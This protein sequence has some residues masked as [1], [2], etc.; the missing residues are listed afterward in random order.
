MGSLIEGSLEFQLE[1]LVNPKRAQTQRAHSRVRDC[2][3]N[4]RMSKSELSC[5]E[6][7]STNC[8]AEN[9]AWLQ[10]AYQWI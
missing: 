7:P 10:L 3:T 1:I 6:N 8:G 5:K 4:F 9:Q 2:V